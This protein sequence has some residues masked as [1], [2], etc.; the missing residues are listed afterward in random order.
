MELT[1]DHLA[2]T[3]YKADCVRQMESNCES[4]FDGNGIKGS[5]SDT[6]CAYV[7]HVACKHIEIVLLEMNNAGHRNSE[8]FSSSV[9]IHVDFSWP[10]QLFSYAVLARI[11]HESAAP[12]VD[13]AVLPGV[14]GP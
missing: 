9:L 5:N 1:P 14:L 7:A 2:Q 4:L 11:I 10:I 13:K 3:S 12:N 6:S 8:S